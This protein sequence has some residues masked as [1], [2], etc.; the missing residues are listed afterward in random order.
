[1]TTKKEIKE[2]LN[3][4]ILEIG[5]VKPWYDKKFKNWIERAI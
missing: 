2:H 3:I 5:E 1:M 4:A